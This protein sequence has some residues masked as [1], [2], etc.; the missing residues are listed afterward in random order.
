MAN[1][2][3]PTASTWVYAYPLPSWIKSTSAGSRTKA[4][5]RA[6]MIE[7]LGDV[8]PSQLSC[9]KCRSKDWACTVILTQKNLRCSRCTNSNTPCSLVSIYHVK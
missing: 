8:I 9:S 4:I 6:A 3:A 2:T 7:A 1:Q 5:E